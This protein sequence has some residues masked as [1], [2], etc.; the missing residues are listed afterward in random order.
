MATARR[1]QYM[2]VQRR[3]T[4]MNGI[5]TRVYFNKLQLYGRNLHSVIYR[6]DIALVL[7]NTI[8]LADAS[9]CKNLHWELFVIKET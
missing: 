1:I 7:G 4:R 9:A 5:I 8:L 2:K 3:L 6:E